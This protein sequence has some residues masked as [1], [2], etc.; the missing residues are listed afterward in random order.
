[1][2]RSEALRIL[3]LSEDATSDDIR[4]AYRESAQIL[5]PDKFAGKAKLQKRA[6]EHFKTLNDAYEY[7]QAHPGGASSSSS[8]SAAGRRAARSAS[9]AQIEARIAG[10][11]AART[12]LVA[13]RDSLLDSRRVG[14]MFLIGGIVAAFFLRRIPA[15][16]SLGGVAVVWGLFDVLSTTGNISKLNDTLKE[17]AEERKKLLSDLEEMD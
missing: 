17:L 2:N 3:G 9:R 6:E 16:A 1:M 15:I 13:Q 10:I 11:T 12:Q 14:F 7:L 8:A 4:D 5:H